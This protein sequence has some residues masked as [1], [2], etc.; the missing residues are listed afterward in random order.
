M[1]FFWTERQSDNSMP[2]LFPQPQ[3]R[4]PASGWQPRHRVRDR[5]GVLQDV[6]RRLL[7][8]DRHRLG[9]G[10]HRRPEQPDG[11]RGQRKVHAKG[12]FKERLDGKS[13]SSQI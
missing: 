2:F 1:N 13:Q 4:R 10:G 12:E 7:R 5:R 8:P 6:P 3:L 9:G 11:L